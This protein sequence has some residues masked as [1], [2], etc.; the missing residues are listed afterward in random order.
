MQVFFPGGRRPAFFVFLMCYNDIFFFSAAIV[1]YVFV[2]FF[3][4][5]V[6]YLGT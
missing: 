1:F 5:Y 3:L 2:T 4:K 6:V